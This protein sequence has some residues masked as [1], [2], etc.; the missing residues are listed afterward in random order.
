MPVRAD[1]PTD[2]QQRLTAALTTLGDDIAARPT[3]VGADELDHPD[4]GMIA[5]LRLPGVASL[6]FEPDTGPQRWLLGDD[7]SWA[8]VE[9]TTRTVAQHGPRRVWDTVEEL[10]QRWNDHGKPTRDRFGLTVTSTGEHRYW[11]DHP[12]NTWWNHDTP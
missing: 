12:D 8:Y 4:F 6:W 5:A 3:P 2:T 10:H 7:G 9:Q 11:L 1:P